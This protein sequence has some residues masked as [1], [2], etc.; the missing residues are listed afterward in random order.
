MEREGE[1]SWAKTHTCPR[2]DP[3][4]QGFRIDIIE[5]DL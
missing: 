4:I 5:K 1:G 2:A 3:N